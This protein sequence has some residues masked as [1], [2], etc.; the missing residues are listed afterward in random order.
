MAGSARRQPERAALHS[1]GR[2]TLV[3]LLME[4][5]PMVLSDLLALLRAEGLE[6]KPHVI[7]HAI[8]AGHLRRPPRDGSGRFAFSRADVA[9]ARRYLA[10]PPRP[11]RRKQANTSTEGSTNGAAHGR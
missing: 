10:N 11:G 8:V 7:Y 9:A 4:E 3:R 6:A 1:L 2:A 5:S